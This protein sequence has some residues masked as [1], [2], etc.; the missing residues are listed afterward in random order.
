MLLVN[1]DHVGHQYGVQRVLDGVSWEILAGQKIGLVGANG[2]GKSTL[3]RLILGT[4]KPDEGTVF[5]AK[6]VQVGYLA[7]EPELDPERTVWEESLSASAALLQAEAELRRLER[8]MGDPAVAGDAVALDKVM[9]AY[10]RA[11]EF[12]E[13]LDGYR[14]ES[15][16]REALQSVGLP[17]SI[18]DLRVG[19]LSGGQRKLVGLAKL[20]VFPVD[21]LLLDE[22]DN[23]L[24]LEGKAFLEHF[25]T[26]FPGAV[27][28]VSHDRYL[29]DETVTAI[30]ELEGGQVTVYSGNYSAYVTEKRLR[31]L[32]QQ[33]LYEAQQKEIS[34]IQAA[35][36]RFELWA[37][38]VV[39]ER[40]IRQARAR[41]KMLERMDKIERPNL[42]S[43]RMDLELNGWRGSKKVLEVKGLDKLF[44]VDGDVRVVLDG[45]NLL[46]WHGE[47]VGL[48]GANGAGKSVFL[49]C[50]LGQEIPSGGVI[51]IGPSVKV[52][53]YAQRHETLN[54][55][56]TLIEEIRDARPMSEQAAVSFLKRFLFPYQKVRDRV[57]DLSGGERSRL[58]LARLMLSEANFLLLDEPTNNL[59]LPSCEVLEEALEEF[60]G[61]VL[62]VSHD[63]YFLNRMATRMVELDAGA[64]TEYI[65]DYTD[66]L[67]QKQRVAARR[68]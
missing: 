19:A 5:R 66:Y 43:R 57:R 4:S 34:R 62:I 46:I 61:T 28:I 11:Q 16:V 29:L 14:Y 48:V 7:Q 23:H 49:R 56:R 3:L 15:R 52:G 67:E 40:H 25:I 18:L 2:A 22:P 9:K 12:F 42:E 60:E 31:Q 24:D 63:R 37:H 55:D 68:R 36:A 33:Q 26:S 65:G 39:D 38:L 1:L 20:L 35:I 51:E 44:E 21:L 50:L 41:Q 59:D 54:L 13:Q 32:R 53:Y 17:E 47:R 27:V 10:A 6:G 30:A 64:L 8:R 58:Q 45:L